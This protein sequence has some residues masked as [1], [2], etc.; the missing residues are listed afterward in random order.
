MNILDLLTFHTFSQSLQ[1]PDDQFLCE[2]HR[3]CLDELAESE[4]NGL[5]EE[6]EEANEEAADDNN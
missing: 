2:D 1:L 5:E 4:Q 3:S 6:M